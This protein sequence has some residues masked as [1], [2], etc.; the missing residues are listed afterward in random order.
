MKN[1]YIIG[2]LIIVFLLTDAFVVSSKKKREKIEE[3]EEYRAIYISYLEYFNHFYGGSKT[4]NQNK[5]NK[6]IDKILELNF[7]VIILHV[8]P[9]SDSIYKSS[10][11]P[12]SYTLTGKEGKYPG[13]DYLEYFIKIAHQK[14]ILLYAWINPYRVSFDN[15][16]NKLSKDNPAYKLFNTTSVKIDNKGIY[17]NPA[18]EVVKNLIISE[19]EE[20]I[21][22]YN[23]DGIHFD[24]YFYLQD[25]IDKLEYENFKKNNG[26]LSLS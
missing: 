8:S 6:M 25:D 21:D 12:Y 11:L 22:N 4:I 5:I 9:F 13:F 1:K 20:I 10:I 7:N 2:L 3:I 23:V 17:L 16:L 15:D 14:N 24:D 26:T 18:S 19:V